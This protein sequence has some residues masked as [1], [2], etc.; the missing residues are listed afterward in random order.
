[1]SELIRIGGIQ[2]LHE[3]AA[4]RGHAAR[5]LPHRHR[6]ARSPR[7]SRRV[8]PYPAGQDDRSAARRSRSRPTATSSV[9]Y[10]NLAP[11]GA[12]AK[13]TGKEGTA[14]RRA[15]PACS[16][17]SSAALR[18][19]LDGMVVAGDVD[20][21]PLRRAEGRAGHARDAEPDGRDHGPGPRRQGGADHGRPF[22]RRQPRFR[23][24]P[25]HAGGRCRRPDRDRRGRRSDRH[26][27]RAQDTRARC[28]EGHRSIG[29]CAR[30]SRRRR[31]PSAVCSRSTRAW[32][33]PRRKAR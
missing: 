33:A 32:S 5:R 15:A 26:R 25:R 14:L 11:E 6:P 13:I 9:L 12:V 22:L 1:M 30:G 2:P 18:A 31:K 10:G 16:T 29:G 7:T 17:A 28:R 21:H 23:R 19:I 4:R 20:R 27:R 24:R 8:Q 3:D